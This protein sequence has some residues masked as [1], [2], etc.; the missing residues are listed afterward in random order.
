MAAAPHHLEHDADV[1]DREEGGWALYRFVRRDLR[2]RRTGLEQE[3]SVLS[4]YCSLRV[5]AAVR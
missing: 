4:S 2:K 3:R 5:A 1:E